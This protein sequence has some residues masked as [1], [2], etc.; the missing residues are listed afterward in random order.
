M[1]RKQVL[2]AVTLLLWVFISIVSLGYGLAFV[3]FIDRSLTNIW[4]NFTIK[5][6]FFLITIGFCLI[7]GIAA[8][9][10]LGMPLSYW[11]LLIVSTPSL[12]IVAIV[13]SR[14][15]AM[16]FPRPLK[17]KSAVLIACLLALLVLTLYLTTGLVTNADTY[18]YHA[19]SIRWIEEYPVVRGLG[20]FFN[21]LAY[22]SNWFVQNA[23]FSFA[24]VNGKSFHV[25]NGFLV[26]LAS[27]FWLVNFFQM[28]A[29]EPPRLFPW[30]GLLLLA[31]GLLT[32][33]SEASAPSTDLPAAYLSWLG[34]FFLIDFTQHQENTTA[35]YAGAFSLMFAGLVKISIAP[36]FLL[37]AF[38]LLR[39]VHQKKKR[40]I[41]ILLCTLAFLILPWMARNIFIS[42]Y[43]VYPVSF[44]GLNV[45]WKIPPGL[46]AG[47]ARGINAW[48]YHPRV[49]VQEIFSMPLKDRILLWFHNI[50][51]NQQVFF[52][53]S[54]LSPIPFWASHWI[55]RKKESQIN[56][57]PFLVSFS[58]YASLIFWLLT[59]PNLR[60]GYVYLLFLVSISISSLVVIVLSWL[61]FHKAGWFRFALQV[62]LILFL[63]GLTVQSFEPLDFRSRLF[64]P[65]DYAERSTYSCTINGEETTIFCASD[66]PR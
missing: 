59:S 20:N 55:Y 44:T 47:D 9:L 66:S 65:L 63:V 29:D 50:T 53:I 36:L 8:F 57:F 34:V 30:V 1:N 22:N 33:G 28:D 3:G 14:V 43:L 61:R 32:F 21:R 6:L 17:W 41:L 48:G 16:V 4:N 27:S 18:I 52:V 23:L 24:W 5:K 35:L 37:L 7:N 2:V 56:G 13:F 19:Q 10:S 25:L 46:V 31:F 40:E 42:G 38:V 62:I 12:V 15:P 51:F 54:L 45:E 26:W 58:F 11:A 64:T 60:F 49:S 39:L